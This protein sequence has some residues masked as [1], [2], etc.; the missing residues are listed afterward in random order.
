M[1]TRPRVCPPRGVTGSGLQYK[2][3]GATDLPSPLSFRSQGTVRFYFHYSVLLASNIPIIFLSLSLLSD[4]KT[5][6][7]LIGMLLVQPRKS[8]S[9]FVLCFIYQHILNFGLH[10][11]FITLCVSG[12]KKVFLNRSDHHPWAIMILRANG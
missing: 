2:D 3:P 9:T 7:N 5:E 11:Y 12:S 4:I 1:A 6:L 8:D 10:L